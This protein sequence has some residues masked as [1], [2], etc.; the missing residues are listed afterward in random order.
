MPDIPTSLSS[1]SGPDRLSALRQN[2]QSQLGT[3]T[4]RKIRIELLLG[5]GAFFVLIAVLFLLFGGK[6]TGVAPSTSVVAETEQ[7]VGQLQTGEAFTAIALEEG[8]FPPDVEKG[9]EVRI[10]VT[11]NADGSGTTRALEETTI[12]E[13]LSGTSDVGG[14]YVMTVRGPESVVLAIAA[15]GNVHI[16][17]VREA[18]S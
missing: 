4:Q 17:I 10:V 14:R 11:P 6:S 13:S 8:S 1:S 5:V 7:S 16:A 15:S 2:S 12:V 9:D 3:I 18:R